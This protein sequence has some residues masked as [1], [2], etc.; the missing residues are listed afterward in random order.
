MLHS[1]LE[2]LQKFMLDKGKGE[3]SRHLQADVMEKT[4]H[5]CARLLKV[6]AEEIT[7]LSSA[8]EGINLVAYGLDWRP[9]DNVVVGDVEFPSDI[10]PWTKLK[11]YGVEIRIVKNKDW[12]LDENDILDQ[13]DENT[14]LVAI[15]QVSMFT[16]QH[17]DVPMLSEGIRKSGALLLL[18]VTH[19]A[20]VVPVDARYADIAVSSCYKWLLGTHGTAIFYCNKDRLPELQPP[21][22]GW[23]SVASSGGWKNPLDFT[24]HANA[25]RFLAANP[26]YVSIYILHNA[27]NKL[28]PLG[29]SA[30]YQHALS[31]TRRLRAG[32]AELGLELMTPA[33]DRRRSGNVCFMTREV[34]A[35]RSKL[36]EKGILVWGAYGRF[37]RVRA[38]THVYNDS[39]DVER[40]LS[41]LRTCI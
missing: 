23:A 25:D 8:T 17:M 33:E 38:S 40:F 41:E 11:K 12:V 22:I 16:G 6:S 36:E 5:Q 24:L 3:A 32:I 18:D 35:L 31:L 29:E 7:F 2:I 39:S 20:G 19:A 26:S 30:V 34:E 21:F 37:G 15:S 28:L 27:L 1:H 4:R 10:L 14:K 13:V 9:G